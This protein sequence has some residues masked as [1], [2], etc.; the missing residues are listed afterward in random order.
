MAPTKS[1]ENKTRGAAIVVTPAKRTRK[2]GNKKQSP[3][4]LGWG[5]HIR[6]EEEAVPT[7]DKVIEKL[8]AL[9]S[10]MP[11]PSG[12]MKDLSGHLERLLKTARGR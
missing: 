2:A 1:K 9:I 8:D 4:N 3:A 11:Y 6:A 10:T 12:Q 5:Q 7:S